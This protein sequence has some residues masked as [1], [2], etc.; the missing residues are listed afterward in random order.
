MQWLS[1]SV[2]LEIDMDLC[3]NEMKHR[4][5]IEEQILNKIIFYYSMKIAKTVKNAK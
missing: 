3:E 1:R 4:D 5:M 2:D